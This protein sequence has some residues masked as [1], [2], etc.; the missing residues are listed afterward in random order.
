MMEHIRI[1]DGVEYAVEISGNGPETLVLLHGF[2]GAASS[3]REVRD[4]LVTEFRIVIIELPGHGATQIVDIKDYSLPE[5]GKAITQLLTLLDI[6]TA[7]LWGYSMGGRTA[8]YT[9]VHHPQDIESLILESASPGLKTEPEKAARRQADAVLAARLLR[10]GITAFV[11]YW[12]QIPL[13]ASQTA[14]SE[15]KR[16]QLHAQ[17]LTN[18]PEGLANSLYQMGTGAQ[19]SLWDQLPELTIPTLIMTGA[20]DAKFE[21]IGQEMA[22]L[23]PHA[24]HVSIKDTGHAISFERPDQTTKTVSTFISELRR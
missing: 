3:W 1:A 12:E 4:R 5:T 8:L 18:S 7:H 21:A 9:A 2:T 14:V 15:Q 23:I 10:E 16:Q 20:L 13:F 17:R 24:R 22:A 19:P 11:D 6:K